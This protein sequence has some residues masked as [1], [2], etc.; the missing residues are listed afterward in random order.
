MISAV[1]LVG[2]LALPLLMALAGM[3][4]AWR[5]RLAGL[6]PIAAAPA[7]LLAGQG[8]TELYLPWL[9][10]GLRLGIDPGNAPFVLLTALVWTAAGVYA[11][12]WL[13]EARHNDRFAVFFLLTL[14]GN[15]GVVLALDALGFYGF[16]ALMAFAAYGLIVHGGSPDARQAGRIYLILT[17]VGEALLLTALWLV[18][19]ASPATNMAL[20]ELAA[21]LAAAPRRDLIVGLILAGFAVKMGSV[22][23]HVW[24]PGS[25]RCAPTAASAV[26]GG[27]VIKAGLLGWLRFLPLGQVALPTWGELCLAVGMGSALYG[28]LAGA[29]QTRAKTVVAYSSISQMGLLTALLGIALAAPEAWPLLFNLLVLFS[30]HHGLAKAALFLGVEISSRGA[31]GSGWLLALPALALAG[32]PLT[33]GALAKLGFNDAAAL[34]PGPWAQELPVLLALSSALTTLLM[35]RLLYL[36]WPRRPG[37]W[38]CVWLWAPWIGL[39]AA[40]LVLPGWWALNHLA[41]PSRYAL[42]PGQWGASLMIIG[43]AAVAACCYWGLGRATGWQPTLPE[44]DIVVFFTRS[45]TGLFKNRPLG[46]MPRGKESTG[47]IAMAWTLLYGCEQRLQYWSLAGLG[48]LALGVL[49]VVFLALGHAF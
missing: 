5:R 37:R 14:V 31:P 7:L 38:P 20:G 11:Y 46:S 18:I 1:L 16:F 24:L 4:G 29:L 9:L 13:R 21:R 3:R 27:V 22:P 23:L 41:N 26:L 15:L 17:I 12:G 34:A 35:A 39:L 6:L 33:S 25:Y 47:K 44:G 28:A 8:E 40:G 10:M 32:A 49:L 42:D 19:S 43:G 45:D 36:A 30:L 2:S 48:F